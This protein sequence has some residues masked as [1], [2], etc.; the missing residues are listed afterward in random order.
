MVKTEKFLKKEQ[1]RL[2]GRDLYTTFLTL[3][4][5]KHE[6]QIFMDLTTPLISAF[7][8]LKLGKNFLFVAFKA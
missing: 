8:L 2:S 6:E 1:D 3:L 5:F 4:A 7:I